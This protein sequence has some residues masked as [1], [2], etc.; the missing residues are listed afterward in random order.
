MPIE[1][2]KFTEKDKLISKLYV[3]R[4]G[5]SV[6]YDVTMSTREA[7]REIDEAQRKFAEDERN[8]EKP[9]KALSYYKAE[10]PKL[11]SKVD[12]KTAELKKAQKWWRGWI[13]FAIS[14]LYICIAASISPDNGLD[15]LLIIGVLGVIPIVIFIMIKIIS[16]PHRSKKIAALTNELK[17]LSNQMAEYRAEIDRCEAELQVIQNTPIPANPAIVLEFRFKNAIIPFRDAAIESVKNA[18]EAIGRDIIP[19]SEWKNLDMLIY[20]LLTDQTDSPK[21]ALLLADQQSRTDKIKKALNYGQEHIRSVILDGFHNIE[22]LIIE[23]GTILC[24]QIKENFN[25][26]SLTLAKQIND[27]NA[28]DTQ[29]RISTISVDD[30]NAALLRFSFMT[31]DELV[32][33][34]KEHAWRSLW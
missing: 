24:N 21:E 17:N 6:I 31:S 34:I 8:R 1:A 12:N 7:K 2:S 14:F 13:W 30:L 29:L 22:P 19:T 4:A 16:M 27:K 25:A 9:L 18:M 20:H 15:P 11:Q 33:R 3:L 26:H 10:I 32:K 5:L 23:N 28:K